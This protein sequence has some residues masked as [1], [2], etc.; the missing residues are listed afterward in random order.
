MNITS[1][2]SLL[3]ATSEIISDASHGN[4]ALKTAADSLAN[5]VAT[6]KTSKGLTGDTGLTGL[7]G[8]PG[9]TGDKGLIGDTYLK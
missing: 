6:I 9:A 3:L 5:V 1:M 2:S 8:L 4:I 7:T